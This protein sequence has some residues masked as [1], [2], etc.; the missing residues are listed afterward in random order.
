MSMV[1]L[2]KRQKLA[3]SQRR[4][5]HTSQ[6][7]AASASDP[8]SVGVAPV[9]PAVVAEGKISYSTVY[10][11]LSW[12]TMFVAVLLTCISAAPKA[13]DALSS[14]M[15]SEDDVPSDQDWDDE[16]IISALTTA[17]DRLRSSA[18]ASA[19]SHLRGIYTGNSRTTAWRHAKRKQEEMERGV[20]ENHSITNFFKPV[21]STS[22]SASSSATTPSDDFPSLQ[23][24]SEGEDEYFS[25]DEDSDAADYQE[26]VQIIDATDKEQLA[27]IVE[28][29]QA[30][31][32]SFRNSQ[33]RTSAT[34]KAHEMRY[35]AVKLYVGNMLDQDMSRSK[36]SLYAAMTMF[37]RKHGLTYRSSVC[38]SIRR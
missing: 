2:T 27:A 35:L 16:Q 32:T 34:D 1:P 4:S 9:D 29:L 31:L 26:E 20:K 19:G 3:R 15:E 24:V 7:A 10:E 25:E 8:I 36:A 22:T 37:Q 33:T 12:I 5:S 21:S 6:F 28:D 17:F 14:G 38:K 30:S 18:S 11:Y 23:D 13:A